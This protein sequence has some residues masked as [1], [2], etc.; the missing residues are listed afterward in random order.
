VTD[1]ESAL[2]AEVKR[3]QKI[4]NGLAAR[5]AAQA[6]LLARRAEKLPAQSPGAG[7]GGKVPPCRSE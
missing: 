2:V 3:L 1:R 6:E 4:I 7:A 5:V